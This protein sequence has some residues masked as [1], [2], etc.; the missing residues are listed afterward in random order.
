MVE[1]LDCVNS[2]KN[3][4]ECKNMKKCSDCGGEI[5]HEQDIYVCLEC[6]KCHDAPFYKSVE[7]PVIAQ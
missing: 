4:K 3:M 7:T 6:G 5:V 1:W 2:V